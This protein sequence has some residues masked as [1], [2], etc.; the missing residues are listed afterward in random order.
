MTSMKKTTKFLTILSAMFLVACGPK[1]SSDKRSDPA[2]S[3]NAEL[4]KLKVEDITKQI[5]FNLFGSSVEGADYVY[6]EDEDL[7]YIPVAWGDGATPSTAIA[8]APEYLP[9]GVSLTHEVTYDE[10]QYY[11]LTTY[12]KEE[13]AIDIYSYQ[14]TTDGTIV[15]YDI[16][17]DT[18]YTGGSTN[19][20][21]S[22]E[23]PNTSSPDNTS[24]PATGGDTN[25]PAGAY[26]TATYKSAQ[27]ISTAK[28]I[29]NALFGSAI[30][31]EDYG[32]D[33]SYDL[34]FVSA[35]WGE[36]ST[37]KSA[38]DEAVT[39][40]PAGFVADSKP[41]YD[42]ESDYYYAYYSK[43]A[44]LVDVFSFEV[45]EG[46][47]VEYDIY[48]DEDAID[49][50]TDTPTDEP[51]GSN[52]GTISD[53][54]GNT[55]A[56]L[57]FEGY[58]VEDYGNKEFTSQK[59]GSVT[60]SASKGSGTNQPLVYTVGDALR[61]YS[62]NTLTVKAD[63][64]VTISKIVVNCTGIGENKVKDATN[65]TVSGGTYT[66]T[67]TTG[68]VVSITGSTIVFTQSATSGNVRISSIE[69]TYK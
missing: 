19:S 67:T 30:Y 36:D 35:L 50:P 22:V 9:S 10:K 41:T 69:I 6:D 64:G 20:S 5:A 16:Y 61:L 59:I 40:L 11:Y 65:L 18:N 15:E 28:E 39:L 60:V 54:E 49:I 68:T 58:S 48:L 7:Y 27:C 17:L 37:L 14:S 25:P 32:Y 51:T 53:S 52:S 55:I 8:E 26:N 2:A 57:S 42:S 46:V 29:S 66:A 33:D 45:E 3:I 24:N 44:I 62:G 21:S 23:R 43:G 63:D 4:A 38:I 1:N 13:V 31:D 47:A 34:F 56:T 12:N